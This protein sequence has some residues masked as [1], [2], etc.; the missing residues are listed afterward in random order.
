[1]DQAGITRSAQVARASLILGTSTM[2]TLL[3]GFVK[4]KYSAL[5]LGP[6]GLGLLSQAT[7]FLTLLS[8]FCSL[9]TGQGIIKLLAEGNSAP[10]DGDTQKMRNEAVPREQ[11]IKTALLLSIPLAL[12]VAMLSVILARPLA[13]LI[14]DDPHYHM[15]IVL[16][17]LGLPFQVLFILLG[18]F[19]RGFREIKAYGRA[20]ILS[21]T[22]NLIAFLLLAGF[23]NLWGALVAQFVGTLV[24]SLTF[25][26]YCRRRIAGPLL[27][28]PDFGVSRLRKLPRMGLKF[29]IGHLQPEIRAAKI[30][31]SFG[32][33]SL[34]VVV[35]EL[36]FN[37]ILRTGVVHHLG[38]AYNGLYQAVVSL[39][40]QYLTFFSSLVSVYL[41]PLLCSS[42]TIH[43]YNDEMNSSLH[44]MTL[45]AIPMFCG[46]LLFKEDVIRILFSGKFLEAAPLIP[47]QVA[48]DYFK[49]LAK[50]LT[51]SL[52]PTGRLRAWVLFGLVYCTLYLGISLFLLKTFH[53]KGLVIA[54]FLSNLI[55]VFILALFQ[56]KVAKFKF[57]PQSVKTISLSLVLLTLIIH[58]PDTN[59]WYNLIKVGLVPVW[60]S[61]VVSL[62]EI[63]QLV[64]WVRYKTLRIHTISD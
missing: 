5:L 49:I 9:E 59:L 23:F 55:Y 51:A 56:V 29:K 64:N 28:T 13:A 3:V 35:T 18:V 22:L 19:L 6:T 40:N 31:L 45:L 60:L 11:I 8:L 24:S 47:L 14:F 17:S 33:L 39:S 16:V 43:E 25:Y 2:V 21:T 61:L 4:N 34:A 41:Y 57:Y 54:Y 20:V 7:G 15:A 62:S 52:L 37:L 1:M 36:T 32:L 10:R 26:A 27:R 46:L 63:R 48:G 50:V 53:L 58:L 30:L 44:F 42:K 38:S 12:L